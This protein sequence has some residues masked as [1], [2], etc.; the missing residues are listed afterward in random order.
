MHGTRLVSVTQSMAID[1]VGDL[2]KHHDHTYFARSNG[3]GGFVAGGMVEYAPL[4][5]HRSTYLDLDANI[6][7][8]QIIMQSAVVRS[9]FWS[10]KPLKVIM[11]KRKGVKDKKFFPPSLFVQRF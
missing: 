7:H 8:L 9:A 3:D 10:D 6:F 4:V 11:D 1:P 5:N 2:P